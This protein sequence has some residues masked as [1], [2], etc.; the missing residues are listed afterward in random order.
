MINLNLTIL[1]Q[2]L[3][4]LFLM[5]VLHKI[6][7]KPMLEFLD[8]RKKNIAD[9]LDRAKQA[10][11]EAKNLLETGNEELKQ[12]RLEAHE[13]YEKLTDEAND[14][15]QRIREEARE[16]ADKEIEKAKEEIRQMVE[17]AKFELQKQVSD[18]S[19]QIAE[20]VITRELKATDHEQL[21]DKYIKNW[22]PEVKAN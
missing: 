10:R 4:F 8:N 21:I 18:L 7:Y 14:E 11:L 9:S 6:L 1:S 19:I 17:Q 13:I 22:Q 12:K 16:A 3:S 20:Q 15:A 2:I 5:W